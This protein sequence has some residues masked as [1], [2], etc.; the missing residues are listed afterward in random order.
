MALVEP[1]GAENDDIARSETQLC[2]AEA[3]EALS[4]STAWRCGSESRDHGGS[5]AGSLLAG[6][7]SRTPFEQ[8][9]DRQEERG[10]TRRCAL[11]ERERKTLS[12]ALRAEPRRRGTVQQ[13][14]ELL[15]GVFGAGS[16]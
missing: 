9:I 14:L 1:S 3:V 8:A 11:C 5:R 16:F 6:C 13:L 10:P 12:I 7:T 2:L 4:Q 15:F